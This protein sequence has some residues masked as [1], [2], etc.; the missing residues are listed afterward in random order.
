MSRRSKRGK[1]KQS[2]NPMP[3]IIG[4]VGAIAAVAV[5]FLFMQG[6][7][8]GT[9]DAQTMSYA[10]YTDG[11]AR[12]MVG[13]NYTVIGT[14]KDSEEVKGQTVLTLAYEGSTKNSKLLVLFVAPEVR[15]AHSDINLNK[16]STYKFQVKVIK[17]GIIQVESISTK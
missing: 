4:A 2:V 10:Q 6:L 1:S 14:V 17:D 16:E 11:G 7:P 15:S 12:S 8:G 5:V 13:N 3:I 9:K